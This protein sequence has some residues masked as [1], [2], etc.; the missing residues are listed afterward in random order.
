MNPLLSGQRWKKLFLSPTSSLLPG[1][2]LALERIRTLS[3]FVRSCATLWLAE[4]LERDCS[5]ISRSWLVFSY[6]ALFRRISVC[7]KPWDYNRTNQNSR[8][9]RSM[10]F[11]QQQQVSRNSSFCLRRGL[12][13][14]F[15]LH[16]FLSQSVVSRDDVVILPSFQSP[17]CRRRK[18]RYV[19]MLAPLCPAY[20]Y[21]TKPEY[22]R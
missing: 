21:T 15:L 22:T 1:K 19:I 20:F 8:T 14:V 13:W 2:F 5:C 3:G 11:L 12:A 18:I 7:Q 6:K 9:K 4:C 10:L 17:Y 16:G